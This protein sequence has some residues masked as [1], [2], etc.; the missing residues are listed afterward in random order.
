MP[1]RCDRSQ[2]LPGPQERDIITPVS[3]L[4]VKHREETMANE[5]TVTIRIRGFEDPLTAYVELKGFEDPLTALQK[6]RMW[7]EPLVMDVQVKGAPAALE[8]ATKPRR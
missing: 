6:Y 7:E 4:T 2:R 8:V 5:L 3:N 1:V